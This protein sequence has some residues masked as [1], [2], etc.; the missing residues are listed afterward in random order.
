MMNG[1]NMYFQKNIWNSTTNFFAI[2]ARKHI[3]L[4]RDFLVIIKSE[5]NLQNATTHII[6]P[7]SK[8]KRDYVFRLARF[9]Y[10]YF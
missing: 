7:I 9:L 1:E 6:A 2:F 4:R 10:T 3:Q 5:V 8:I